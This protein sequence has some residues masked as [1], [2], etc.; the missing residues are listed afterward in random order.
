MSEYLKDDNDYY[1]NE[2]NGK[3]IDIQLANACSYMYKDKQGIYVYR[4]YKSE[5]GKFKFNKQYIEI[6]KGTG[7]VK[8]ILPKVRAT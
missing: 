8:H 4:A 2:Q 1:Q 5:V 3:D 6:E 7:I